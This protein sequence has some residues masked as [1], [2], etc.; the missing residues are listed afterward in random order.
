MYLYRILKDE[1]NNIA[2]KTGQY[3]KPGEGG[4]GQ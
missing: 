1:I 4:L 3:T 2:L